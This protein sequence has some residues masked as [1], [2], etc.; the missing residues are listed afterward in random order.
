[1]AVTC[2]NMSKTSMEAEFGY[3]VERTFHRD[4]LMRQIEEA[5]RLEKEEGTIL[6]DK[7]E[8]RQPFSVQVRATRMQLN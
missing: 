6:N 1:M 3:K 5:W 2:G 7:F 4:S 8:F